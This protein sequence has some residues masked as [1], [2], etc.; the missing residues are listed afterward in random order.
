MLDRDPDA[1]GFGH[2]TGE[3]ADGAAYLDAVNGFINSPEFLATY[4]ATSN[5]E[6]VTLLYQ[7]VL[8]REPD[9]GGL[10]HWTGQL[11]SAAMTRAEVVRGFAQSTEF[12]AASQADFAT[13]ISGLDRDDR[14]DG[15]AGQN[16]LFGGIGVDSFVFTAPEGGHHA[17]A[18]IEPWDVIELAGS[19]HADAAAALAALAPDGD[20]VTLTDGATTIRFHDTT[21]DTFT[22]DMFQIV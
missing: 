17:V 21:L 18:D 8:D 1:G 7:N 11:D 16:V 12:I 22:E 5:A 15:G 3:L 2:W 13:W 4:G 10:A 20:D 6:F 19:S 9:D 14:L